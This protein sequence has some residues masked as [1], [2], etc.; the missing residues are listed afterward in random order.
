MTDSSTGGYLVPDPALAAPLED[1]ALDDFMHDLVAGITGLDPTLVRPRWQPEPPNMPPKDTDWVGVGIPTRRTDVF[2]VIEHDPHAAGGLGADILIRH[3][4][5][6]LLCSFYGPHCQA[7]AARLRDGLG[8]AQNREPMAAAGMALVSAGDPTKA[9]EMIKNTWVGRAD[10]T[11]VIKRV[12]SR[13][14][15]VLNLLS[16]EGTI[17]TEAVTVAFNTAS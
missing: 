11:V 2:P 16:A 15:A 14:Y 1:D 10:L 17:A 4:E 7:Y 12:I 3:E 8:I 9:P 6:D 5:L 13:E